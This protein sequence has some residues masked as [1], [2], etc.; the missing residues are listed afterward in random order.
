M[1]KITQ[2]NRFQI[3]GIIIMICA[4]II[5]AITDENWIGMIS[6]VSTAIGLSLLLKWFPYYKKI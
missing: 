2:L 1:A 5:S 3:L 4:V 6:G